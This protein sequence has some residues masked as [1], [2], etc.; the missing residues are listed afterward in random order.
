MN[1]ITATFGNGNM[2]R[3]EPVWQIDYGQY[4]QFAD[5]ELPDQYQVIFECGGQA[6]TVLGDSNGAE[7]PLAYIQSGKTIYARVFLHVGEDDGEVAYSATIPNIAAATP[8]DTPTPEQIDI[9]NQLI[10]QMQSQVSQMQTL[11]EQTQAL[12]SSTVRI[13]EDGN[14][15]T[16]E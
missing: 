10:G 14:F 3:T 13:D 15:V 7:I 8:G 4:I 1:I 5:V 16:G 2:T 11:L 12:I 9:I 6:C